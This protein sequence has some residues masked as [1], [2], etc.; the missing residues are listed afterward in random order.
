MVV[1]LHTVGPLFGPIPKIDLAGIDWVIVGGESGV[2]ALLC[3][4]NPF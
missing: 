1:R 2:F 3:S 4:G